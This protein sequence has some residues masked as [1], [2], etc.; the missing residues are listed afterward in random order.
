MRE[1][2][3]LAYS[4]YSYLN[5]M[6]RSGVVAGGV[7]TENERVGE[8]L[9]VI[10]REW[11]R[12]GENGPTA[13]ELKDAKTYLTGSYPPRFS[14]SGSIAGMLLGIQIE[15]LGIDYVNR[16]NDLIEAVTL[17]DVRRVAAGLYRVEDLTVVVVGRPDGVASAGG[18]SDGDG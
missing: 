5:P 13:E 16:R 15:D 6:E 12:M 9:E 7:A 1:K 3:G 11:A 10:R 4:V 17:E 8:S 18:S 2:R 14:S